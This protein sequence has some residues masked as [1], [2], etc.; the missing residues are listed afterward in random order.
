M[1]KS[2]SLIANLA[3]SSKTLPADE[4]IRL[5]KLS[6][7]AHGPAKVG[8]ELGK[9]NLPNEGL[10]DTLMRLALHQAKVTRKEAERM[11]ARFGDSPGF[12]PPLRKI[13]G[14]NPAV[15]KGHLN[16]RRIADSASMNGFTVLER[17]EKFADGRKNAPTDIDVVL[18]RGSTRFAIEAK[19][20][21]PARRIPMDQYRADLDTLVCNSQFFQQPIKRV[22][23]SEQQYIR[24]VQLPPL[25]SLLKF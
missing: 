8:E 24:T 3:N 1:K 22:S 9:L 12:R 17:G 5:S 20:S 10:E 13:I 21:A 4:I 19:D 11:L 7:E 25:W 15:A 14:N 16:E 18:E 2:P 6:E 23:G